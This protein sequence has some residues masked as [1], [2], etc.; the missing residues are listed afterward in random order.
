M[1]GALM[2]RGPKKAKE[3]EKIK[4]L[5]KFICLITAAIILCGLSACSS[6]EQ[7][8]SQT[9][10]MLDTFVTLYLYPEDEEFFAQCFELA[11]TLEEKLSAHYENGE[12]YA[13]NKN[14]C[15][16]VSAETLE[17]IKKGIYY[18]EL[19]KGKFDISILPVSRLWNF[20]GGEHEPP[21]A[22]ALKEAA[23]KIDYTRIQISGD[24]VTLEEGMELDLG[25]IA[26]GYAADRL[27]Q[28]LRDNGVENA[29][30]DLGGNIYALGSRQGNPF[31]IGIADPE[32]PQEVIGY[33]ELTNCSAVTSGIYQRYSSWEGER[34]HH[35]LDPDTGLPVNNS[36]ASATVISQ[37]STDCDAL[38][39]ICM[40]LGEE[41]ALELINS[42]EGVS[43]VLVRRDGGIILSQGAEEI[44]SRAG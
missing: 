15:V 6:Q 36:L 10:F 4:P 21:A 17:V 11:Q 29:L 16:K 20:D 42:L 23:A 39:T 22:Q 5:K 8:L 9:R 31:R 3:R 34:Y 32:N 14:K 24:T 38:S 1:W 40:L 12:I 27:A 37:N 35:I 13:L 28:F 7:M 41:K 19:S 33:L 44:F 2:G 18:G 26:K 25:G 43:A 30:L